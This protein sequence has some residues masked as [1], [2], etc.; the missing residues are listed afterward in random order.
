MSCPRVS[1]TAPRHPRN[2]GSCWWSRPPPGIPAKSPTRQSLRRIG[3]HG[4]TC[5]LGRPLRPER[6]NTI[7]RMRVCPLKRKRPEEMPTEILMPALSPTMEEGKLAKWLVTEG[8]TIKPGDII[9]EIETDKATMEVEA[10]DEGKVSKLLIPAGTEGVKVNTPIAVLDGEAALQPC[11]PNVA[12]PRREAHASPAA[13]RG[14]VRGRGQARQ[15]RHRHRG[16][17]PP[18]PPPQARSEIAPGTETVIADHAR[19]AARCHGR[20]DAARPRRVP[21]GRGGGA[22]PG[23]LQDQPGPARGVRRPSA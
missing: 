14:R 2:P 19:G 18:Q 20:G 9:A 12:S 16:S 5:R 6:P 3:A 1:S 23:R 17:A 7:E 13:L 10:V 8:Q 11:R 22:V 4:C 15:L 21:D